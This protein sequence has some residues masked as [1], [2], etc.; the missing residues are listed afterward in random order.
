MR[1]T[2]H[3]AAGCVTGSRF[4]LEG[5]AARVLVDCG[6]FQG[7]KVLRERNW[8]RTPFDPASLDAVVLTHAHV[9]H[10]G[11][12]PAL[13]RDGFRGDVIT[14]HATR[15]LCAIL[16]PD[17]GR[18]QEEDARRANA[19]GYSKHRPALPLYTEQDAHAALERF[20]CV[21]L[22]EAIDAGGLTARFRDA[23]HIL[24]AASV[25][26]E[27]EG[28]RVLFSGDLGRDDDLLMTAPAPPG[29]P[30]WVVLES[31]YGDRLHGDA[32]PLRAIA[33][34]IRRAL[35][36]GGVVLVPAFAVGRT[37][38]MLYALHELFERGEL[39]RVPVHVDSPM[40]GS[41]TE[42]YRAHLAEHRLDAD[43]CAAVCDVAS[44]AR[45]VD[46]SKAIDRASGPRIVVSASGMLTG[47]RVLHH[48][49]V[50]GPHPRNLILVPGFAAPGTRAADL[51][52]GAE[53][54]KVHG[55]WLDVRAEVVQLSNLSAHADQAGLLA[56]LGRCE[57]PPRGVFLVHGE[58]AALEA[59][60]VRVRDDLRLPVRVADHR[61][62]VDLAAPGRAPEP[63][64]ARH[65]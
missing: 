32:D 57:R 22:G 21:G 19:E 58:P 38:A 44:Y 3:G 45:T 62:Q 59:L 17:S 30:D 37:Q 52:A 49:R 50:F 56:W 33:D 14:T 43:S 16:L 41:V 11:F 5:A 12:L 54:V 40:A 23:G 24:G 4:L 53:R 9:D 2:F 31:T 18:I 48:L 28:T 27:G 61:D 25:E 60:R 46:E 29:S 51:A 20:R 7:F 36:R 55:R 35:E 39:P 6:L 42:L 34:P 47:G 10:S 1:L 15:D 26:L 65:G 64:A 13:V 63:A 8:A